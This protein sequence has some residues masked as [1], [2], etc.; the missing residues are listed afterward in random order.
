MSKTDEGPAAHLWPSAGV[1][2][3]A[4]RTTEPHATAA[5]VCGILGLTF[6]PILCS[7]LAVYFATSARRRIRA[8]PHAI[9]GKGL[10]DAGWWLGLAG[11]ILNSYLLWMVY[12]RIISPPIPGSVG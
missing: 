6:V 12:T 5:L 8:A 11:L 3:P 7:F 9:E 10:A 1:S 2:A 4:R